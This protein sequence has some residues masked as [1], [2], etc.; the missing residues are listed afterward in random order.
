M[1]NDPFDEEFFTYL[2]FVVNAVIIYGIG[3]FSGA[4]GEFI[5]S[6]IASLIMS[7]LLMLFLAPIFIIEAFLFKGFFSL[8]IKDKDF[9]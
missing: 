3:L 4:F 6:A 5:F 8:F 7:F 2:T 9:V 1:N